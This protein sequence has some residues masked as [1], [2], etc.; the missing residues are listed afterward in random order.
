[1]ETP[2][3][4]LL[5]VQNLPNNYQLL[6]ILLDLR[7]FQTE[8]CRLSNGRAVSSLPDPQRIDPTKIESLYGDFG[9]ELRSYIAA[10]LKDQELAD[11]VLQIVL[12]KTLEQGHQAHS[13][14]RGWM[15]RVALQECQLHKREAQ[16]E[17]RILQKAFWKTGHRTVSGEQPT[18]STVQQE[19][20][21]AVRQ[22]IE[23]LTPDQQR[24]VRM[25]IYE[26]K[27]FAEIANELQIP[28][29][30]AL[31]RMRAATQKLEAALQKHAD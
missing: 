26:D 17:Q 20:V 4:K 14:I 30:T 9:L 23:S 25:R 16:R 29:G 7:C 28:L 5:A 1:M 18:A 31:T 3:V 13:N 10:I 19:V 27:T 24:V 2:Q 15:F 11:E 22:A 21:A 8:L 6:R 12:K